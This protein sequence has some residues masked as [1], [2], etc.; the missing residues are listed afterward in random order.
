[1]KT[2]E[3]TV[4]NGKCFCIGYN[5]SAKGIPIILVHGMLLNSYFW[6]TD[7]ISKIATDNPVYVISLAGYC[8]SEFPERDNVNILI[9]K[10][11]TLL[12]RPV[13]ALPRDRLL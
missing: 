3:F 1:M 4:G 12:I 5:T 13:T 2:F 8:P 7:K 6:W 11:L 10:R 9:N